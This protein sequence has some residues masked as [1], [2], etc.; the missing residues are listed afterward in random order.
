MLPLK[1]ESIIF[2]EA[3]TAVAV[4]PEEQVPVIVSCAVSRYVCTS[5]AIKDMHTAEVFHVRNV[6]GAKQ[7]ELRSL[8]QVSN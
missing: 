8:L 1:N 3:R 4:P 7:T 2:A 5:A 6:I